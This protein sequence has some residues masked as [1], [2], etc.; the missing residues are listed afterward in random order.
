[1]SGKSLLTL[2]AL[3]GSLLGLSAGAVTT[4][5]NVD[6]MVMHGGALTTSTYVNTSGA[7]VS[8]GAPLL[9][10]QAFRRGDIFLNTNCAIPR[11]AVTHNPL[12]WQHDNTAT[13]RENGDDGSVRHWVFGVLTDAPVPA[14]GHYTIE[15]V[16][17]GAPC[18]AQAAHQSLAAL[19][20]THDLKLHF[21]N[22][23]NQDLTMR[24]SGSLTFD[25]NA[26]AANTGR[27]APTKYATG[28]VYDGWRVVGPPTWDTASSGRL[29][30]AMLS[31]AQMMLSNWIGITNGSLHIVIDGTGHD[32]TGINL[33]GVTSM[34]GVATAINSRLTVAGASA[35]M[36][37]DPNDQVQ[38]FQLFS[39]S[40]GTSS[41]V[42][43]LTAAASGT[44][45]S[46][47]LLMT[48]GATSYNSQVNSYTQSGLAAG[49]KDPLL[50][51]ICYVDVTTQP[52]GVTMGKVR[53]TCGIH[54]S[55]MN[56]TAG[57]T[58]NTGA[59]GP[60]GYANDP[61]LIVYR[62]TL[63]DG[64]HTL[65]DWGAMFD[66]M[67][68]VY[69]SQCESGGVTSCWQIPNS[70]GNTPWIIG[71]TFVYTTTGTPPTCT[72]WGGGVSANGGPCNYVQGHYYGAMPSGTAGR[73]GLGSTYVTMSDT[74]FGIQNENVGAFMAPTSPGS[75]THSFSYRLTHP[76]NM[77][78]Y[79]FTSEGFAPWSDGT[80]MSV[81]PFDIAFD[82]SSFSGERL[83]WEQTGVVPPIRLTGQSPSLGIG[84]L[85]VYGNEFYMPMGR[86]ILIGGGGTGERPELDIFNQYAGS[87]WY[88]MSASDCLH[89][90]TLS[91][92]ASIYPYGT[93]LN[94]ATGYIPPANSGPLTGPGGSGGGGSY[95]VLGAP[96]PNLVLDGHAANNGIAYALD[97]TP[98]KNGWDGSGTPLHAGYSYT[99][100]FWREGGSYEPD[101]E[102]EF[103]G[104]S[105]RLYGN[106]Q[107]LDMI[108]LEGERMHVGHDRGFNDTD[109]GVYYGSDIVGH[110]QTRGGH[111]IFRDWSLA[112]AFGDDNRPERAYFNDSLNEGYNS[113]VARMKWIDG[114]TPNA[115]EKSI[116]PPGYPYW[117]ETFVDVFG[118]ST[119]AMN[120][121]MLH[122]PL[123]K[124][125]SDRFSTLL[126][127]I[128]GHPASDFPAYLSAFGCTFY[129]RAYAI[130][131]GSVQLGNQNTGAA[132][133]ATDASDY[134]DAGSYYTFTAGSGQVAIGSPTYALTAGD[135]VKNWGPGYDGS[136]IDQLDPKVKYKV[137]GPISGNTFYV[138]CPAGHMVDA[139]C[140]TPGAAF[141]GFTA[142]GA[143]LNTPYAILLYRPQA[144]NGGTSNINYM[145]YNWQSISFLTAIGYNM[146]AAIN[147]FTTRF[148]TITKDNGPSFILDPT[149]VV[150]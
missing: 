125:Y 91:L 12:I 77:S 28:P 93:L 8:A 66:G 145:P 55:W 29:I 150:Q 80:T 65:I 40:T 67:G 131:D 6:I 78:W 100:G 103:A 76:K 10:A 4:S 108:Y 21:T 27:D 9:M 34:S 72:V 114:A 147:Q 81:S 41:T 3:I 79:T 49:S 64:S 71:S 32:V 37:F 39:N 140:P 17:S 112:A 63:L 87:C 18:P 134:G 120:Y 85:S 24:G 86:G 73:L 46:A 22:L 138:Q 43:F 75:G 83:Y 97:G 92:A 50:Y 142:N 16:S 38:R 101:H 68:T 88:T 94:E 133:N 129:S 139:T 19:A 5:R 42:A 124:L 53:P 105:Y 132:Y 99:A 14:G 118:A 30:G 47:Q 146:S 121:A 54:N 143:P 56:V 106:P 96:W 31:P 69:A 110:A 117:G 135:E 13:R 36:S 7:T 58:G 130:K 123:G 137:M 122:S 74:I 126:L 61:Q 57:S 119:G 98:I 45:I 141:T 33:S 44:D 60:A 136:V 25:I 89:A 11:N 52:D 149:V 2:T 59:P 70:T 104:I 109:T 128:C 35:T 102:P 84:S 26:A 15:W 115:Y 116:Q 1:M 90:R 127:D 82:Q 113:F 111:W 144:D 95:P 23:V 48:S 148:G 51:V 62:P 20:S 107:F